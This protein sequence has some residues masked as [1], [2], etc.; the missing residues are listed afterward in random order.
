[1]SK[2]KEEVEY[3]AHINRIMNSPPKKRIHNRPNWGGGIPSLAPQAT[4]NIRSQNQQRNPI[5]PSNTSI[6]ADLQNKFDQICMEINTQRDLNARLDQRIS[7][8]EIST[9]SI[10]SKMDVLLDRLAPPSSPNHK[11]QRLSSN[12]QHDSMSTPWQNRTSSPTMGSAS[13]CHP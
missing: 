9:K 3:T 5:P 6:D 7:S 12:L 8:L 13:S 4:I 1:L 10:D 2:N 11:M